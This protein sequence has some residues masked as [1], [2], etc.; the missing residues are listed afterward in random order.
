MAGL[1]ARLRGR[2]SPPPDASSVT[3]VFADAAIAR[4]DLEPAAPPPTPPAQPKLR[5]DYVASSPQAADQAH[6]IPEEGQGAGAGR[7]QEPPR[8]SS[9]AGYHLTL[10]CRG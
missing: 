8:P 7:T 6:G 10:L 9:A 2:R 4:E 5:R 3:D 1:W